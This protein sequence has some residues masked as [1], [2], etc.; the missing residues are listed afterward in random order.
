MR[1][2]PGLKSTKRNRRFHLTRIEKGEKY[3]FICLF[4]SVVRSSIGVNVYIDAFVKPPIA[5]LDSGMGLCK[6]KTI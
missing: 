5:F 3:E 4:V 2:L 6:N 1:G